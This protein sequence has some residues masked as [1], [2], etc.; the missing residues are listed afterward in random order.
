MRGD[1][2]YHDQADGPKFPWRLIFVLA[3]VGFAIWWLASWCQQER[4]IDRA[5]EAAESNP[6]AVVV[7]ERRTISV[8]DLRPG[9]CVSSFKVVSGPSSD[10]EEA[11]VVPCSSPW[12]FRV[13]NAFVVDVEGPYPSELFFANQAPERCNV[14]A[15][16]YMSPTEDSW[17]R[18]DRV[19]T[20]MYE[21]G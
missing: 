13:E 14:E 20:C 8:F 1:S 6:T 16:F 19:V 4:L 2:D 5:N 7:S 17:D 12:A 10:T 3:G 21:R 11:Y 18:G 9:H 15:N